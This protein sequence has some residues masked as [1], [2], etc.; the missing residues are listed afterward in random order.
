MKGWLD[1]YFSLATG[2]IL[3]V[4]KG[5]LRV[6]ESQLFRRLWGFLKQGDVVLGDR[7]FCSYATMDLLKQQG[8]DSVFRL[9]QKRK[10]DFRTGQRLGQDDHLIV[11]KKPRQKTPTMSPKDF[12]A[13]DPVIELRELKITV[14]FKGFR[15]KS[16]KLI[17]TL[18][19]PVLY[20]KEALADLFLRRWR[21]EL[22]FRDIKATLGMDILRCLSPQMIAK[23][24]QMHLIAYNLIRSL[25][26]QAACS[27]PSATFQIELQ[28]LGRYSQTM[29][30][31]HSLG[32]SS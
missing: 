11:W 1:G 21:V 16:I 20:P 10:S 30:R 2:A 7:A 26:L 13:L 29:V 24:L 22:F 12:Q 15:T 9:H 4:A 28:G 31:R 32:P 19:D 18:L 14:Q 5:T 17:T 25:M 27:L 3:S 8:V 6:H 23:E